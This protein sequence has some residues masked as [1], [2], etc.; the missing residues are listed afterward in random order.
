MV[1]TVD[2][3][4]APEHPYPAAVEDGLA[5]LGWLRGAGGTA[6][7]VD[8]TR[9]AVGGTSAGANLAS[10]V[11]LRAADAG[12]RGPAFQLLVVPVVD[13]TA[14]ATAGGVWAGNRHAPWLTPA[15]M[16]WYRRMY[17]PD[18][19]D[20]S[21]WDASPNLAPEGLLSRMPPTWM[22]VSEQDLLAPEALAFAAQLEGLG[23]P[24]ET[25]VYKG[26]THSLLALNG[27][28]DTSLYF[29]LG[30]APTDLL[31]NR[32]SLSW[33]ELGNYATSTDQP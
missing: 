13:N 7:G 6:L 12:C 24:V 27:M 33:A 32:V 22:A 5:A 10:A 14:T 11:A 4:L 28:V 25:I 17:M 2:Y 1:C 9:V 19:R 31:R 30:R 16:T 18:E 8:A 20:W 21:S 23:V 29:L 26:S 15:R 3:R